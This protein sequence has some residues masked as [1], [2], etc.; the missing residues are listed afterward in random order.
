MRRV[1]SV[2]LPCLAT[3][4]LCRKTPKWRSE[5]LTT[6]TAAQGGVRIS[7]VNYSAQNSGIVPGLLLADARALVP[8]LRV[9][10]AEPVEDAKA[11]ATLADWCSRYTP[12]A[13]VDGLDGLWLD[14]TGCAHLFDG[15]A[16]LAED[17]LSRLKRLGFEARIGL[18]DSPGAAWAMA[19]FHSGKTQIIANCDTRRTLADLP[20]AALRLPQNIVEGLVRVG[21]GRIGD[22]LTCP[23]TPLIARFGAIVGERIDQALGLAAEPIS[24]RRPMPCWRSRLGFPEPL[25]RREDIAAATRQLIERLCRRLALDQRGVRRLELNLY[26]V[27]GRTH[28]STF[29]TSRPVREPAHLMQLLDEH[30]ENCDPGFGIDVVILA[31]LETEPLGA[32]QLDMAQNLVDRHESADEVALAAAIGR[33][34]DRLSNRLGPGNVSRFAARESHVPE[35]AVYLIPALAAPC[36]VGTDRADS[37]NS[38]RPL[39]MFPSPEPVEAIAPVPDDPPMLFRWRRR[40][41]R[42]V[43]AD[44]PERISPE[45][46]RAETTGSTRDYYRVEDS[47]GRRFWLYREGFYRPETKPRWYVHG[48]FA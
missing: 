11:L 18:A 14:I 10:D 5:P 47:S 44:G 24:P 39:R 45:W 12:W 13:A 19:R 43:H 16:A 35:R 31:A 41:H 34:V 27:D 15:E 23:R 33:L 37:S 46:W 17:I 1:I 28:R 36:C 3:D 48:I 32:V 40:T 7:A 9:V 6:A 26:M 38:Q 20:S 4:R 22:L 2:W 42:I 25:C 29:G 8:Q 21:L 30:F